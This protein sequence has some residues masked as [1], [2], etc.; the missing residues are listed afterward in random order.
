[1]ENQSGH[2]LIPSPSRRREA[3][4]ADMQSRAEQGHHCASCSGVC[5]TFL[6]NSMQITPVEAQDIKTYLES[7]GRWTKDL[8]QTLRETVHRFRLDQE[9]G[10][11]RRTLRRTYTCPFYRAGPGGCSISRHHKPYGCL[12][13]NPREPGITEGGNCASDQKRLESRETDFSFSERLENQ[14]LKKKWDWISDKQPIP[15]ALL[16][17]R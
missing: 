4:V 6:A 9:L 12:A 16:N 13:F 10:D 15:I 11:G 17:I 2:P 7:E 3:L 5:C 14:R 1:M 8:Q